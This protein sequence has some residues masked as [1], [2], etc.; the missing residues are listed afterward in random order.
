MSYRPRR[1]LV[2]TEG[3]GISLN[4]PEGSRGRRQGLEDK[5]KDWANSGSVQMPLHLTT[6][7]TVK[8]PTLRVAT[9]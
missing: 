2:K 8:L 5:S 9:V 3:Y 6:L 4:C 7:C 1:L